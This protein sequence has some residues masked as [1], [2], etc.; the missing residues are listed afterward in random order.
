ML[1]LYSSVSAEKNNIFYENE[2]TGERDSLFYIEVNNIEHH[3]LFLGNLEVTFVGIH[4][5][6]RF[7]K[8]Y[9]MESSFIYL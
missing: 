6:R 4:S 5:K 1:L 2:G 9:I 7:F 8:N 3:L